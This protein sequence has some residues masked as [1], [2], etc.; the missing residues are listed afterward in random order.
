MRKR[1]ATILVIM[2]SAAFGAG[3]TFTYR[4]PIRDAYRKWQ[5]GPIP[6]ALPRAQVVARKDETTIAPSTPGE[7]V[8][9]APTKDAPT[10]TAKSVEIAPAEPKP[11]KIPYSFNLKVPFVP[12]APLKVWDE[13]HEDTCEE[14]SFTMLKAYMDDE[15]LADADEMDRRLL[16]AVE[17]Q[18]KTYG[19]FTS[20]SAARTAEIMR[21]HLGMKN[22]RV[23]PV[24]DII[25]V[26]RQIAAGRPAILPAA[27]KLLFNPNFKNGGPL[28]HMLVAKGYTTSTVIT[29][30]PGTRLG[31]DYAYE[32]EVLWNAIHDWNG[33][34]VENGDRVMIVVGE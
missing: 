16:A 20:S 5:R 17:W 19:D 26:K 18:K 12:Q 1:T 11:K 31:A 25:D 23:L 14:A 15:G 10:S 8:K 21:E 28:Y 2:L 34:D 6:E 13:I 30:D 9:A 22:V 3:A 32:D 33:G 4:T 24:T 27:G 7:T 29:N